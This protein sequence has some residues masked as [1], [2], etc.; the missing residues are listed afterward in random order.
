MQYHQSLAL[1]YKGGEIYGDSR[2]EAVNPLS[3]RTSW[4]NTQGRAAS[5][6]PDGSN[7]AIER[8]D[9]AGKQARQAMGLYD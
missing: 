1:Y 7:S 9:I 2:K 5:V 3:E 8:G 6:D 4:G